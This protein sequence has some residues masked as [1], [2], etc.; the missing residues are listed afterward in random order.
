MTTAAAPADL[1]R[2][3]RDDGPVPVPAG[4]GN[5]RWG[6]ALTAV[7]VL[8]WLAVVAVAPAPWWL[9]VGLA[10]GWLVA[11]GVAGGWTAG[12][13]RIDWLLPVLLRAA[14]YVGVLRL[15]A[16]ADDRALPAAFAFLGVVAFHHYDVV[17]RQQ[18]PGEPRTVVGRLAG[19]WAVRL[20]F[21]YAVAAAGVAR[22]AL[23]WAAVALAVLFAA[24]A[25]TAWWRDPAARRTRGSE[26]TQ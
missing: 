24:D 16:L 3:Y 14:E 5:R 21:A 1:V 7:G 11:F 19:G 22:P 4:Q 18:R 25:V 23:A 26:D 8:P 9:S 13:R 10:L 15:A 20:V 6:L 2:R 12:A 17:Y